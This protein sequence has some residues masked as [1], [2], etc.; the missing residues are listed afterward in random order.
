MAPKDSPFPATDD[1]E[2]D[3]EGL[4]MEDSDGGLVDGHDDDEAGEED[5]DGDEDPRRRS[6]GSKLDELIRRLSSTPVGLRVHDVFIRGNTKTA[7]SVIKAEILVPLRSASTMQ[8]LI[9]GANV[10]SARLRGLGIFDSVDIT[11]DAGPPELPDTANV[12]VEVVESKNPLTGE[13]GVFSKPEV[14]F[15]YIY[16]RPKQFA[17]LIHYFVIMITFAQH[18]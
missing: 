15:D 10:A 1:P 7:E 14:M 4:E 17:H 3:D 8:E 11:L 12:V 5:D 6:N 2:K 13:I 9:Q 16:F 18:M